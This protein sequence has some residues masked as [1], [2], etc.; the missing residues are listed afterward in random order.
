MTDP[1]TSSAIAERVSSNIN[2]LHAQILEKIADQR[3]QL[4]E[5]ERTLRESAERARKQVEQTCEIA[6][7]LDNLTR[8]SQNTLNDLRA[9][10]AKEAT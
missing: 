7:S 9:L 8:S 10:L 1:T 5:F 3:K 2:L 6:E 4:D